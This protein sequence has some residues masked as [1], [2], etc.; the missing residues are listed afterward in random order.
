MLNIYTPVEIFTPWCRDIYTLVEI[1]TPLLKYLN[2][3]GW[4]LKKIINNQKNNYKF[5]LYSLF[6]SIPT[7]FKYFNLCSNIST[8]VQLFQPGWELKKKLDYY[9]LQFPPRFK[10]F[11]PGSNILTDV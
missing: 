3:G 9:L 2:R 11:Y 6:C 4:K 5:C 8:S 7:R 10:Y 1:F